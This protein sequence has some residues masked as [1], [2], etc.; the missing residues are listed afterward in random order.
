MITQDLLS[1]DSC[2]S[3]QVFVIAMALHGFFQISMN[4]RLRTLVTPTPTAPT[5]QAPAS[6]TARKGSRETARTV[7]VRFA[8]R[9]HFHTVTVKGPN[10]LA[11]R[12]NVIILILL[13]TYWFPQMWMNATERH[14]WLIQ[15]FVLGRIHRKRPSLR[16]YEYD[17]GNLKP[18]NHVEMTQTKNKPRSLNSVTYASYCQQNR[19]FKC[20]F[21]CF[22][23]L[24]F[25]RS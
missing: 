23:L 2:G 21:E 14:S 5:L 10:V 12:Q 22:S 4:A 3:F 17:N 15:V 7:Q 19:L 6:V 11:V 20:K 1:F 8:G 24:A 9:F 16:R 13:D 18:I 25:L